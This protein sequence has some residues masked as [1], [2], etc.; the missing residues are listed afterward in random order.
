MP[1]TIKVEVEIDLNDLRRS[2]M[3][4]VSEDDWVE[5]PWTISQA[6]VEIAA[7]R[8]V[9]ELGKDE[10]L[11]KVR[12]EVT[13][14]VVRRHVLSRLEK[15]LT[16]PITVGTGRYGEHIST[17]TLT[18]LIDQEIKQQLVVSQNLSRQDSTLVRVIRETVNAR[19]TTDLNAA[20]LTARDAMLKAAQDAGAAALRAAVTKAVG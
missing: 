2:H 14:D 18:E 1:D 4:Q 5:E 9:E 17:T 11:R 10:Q 6:V 3:R 19:L 16:E 13:R 8:L 12:D 7:A 15:V 20:F